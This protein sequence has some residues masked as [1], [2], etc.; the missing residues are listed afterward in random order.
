MPK[1]P[2]TRRYAEAEARFGVLKEGRPPEAAYASP[3]K[4]GKVKKPASRFLQFT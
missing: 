1:R 4:R 3:R 2:V